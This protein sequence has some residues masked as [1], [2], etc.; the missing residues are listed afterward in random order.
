MPRRPGVARRFA[1]RTETVMGAADAGAGAD[2]KSVLGERHLDAVAAVVD[3][4]RSCLTSG[5]S[6]GSNAEHLPAGPHPGQAAQHDVHRARPSPRGGCPRRSCRPGRRRRR[7]A[8]PAAGTARPPPG[9]VA[10]QHPGGDHAAERRA[11]RGAREVVV[12][13]RGPA[14]PC[15]PR[16]RGCAADSRSS[17]RDSRNSSISTS[18]CLATL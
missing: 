8:A 6:A 1:S 3:A 5:G 11:V 16:S 18:A 4:E 13:G 7:S 9:C 2:L 17:S 12:D 15:S 10:G 14:V